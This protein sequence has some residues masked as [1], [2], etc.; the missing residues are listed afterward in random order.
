M[1]QLEEGYRAYLTLCNERKFD[2]LG[3]F[4]QDPLQLNGQTFAL[5][6]FATRLSKLVETV[7]DFRW[8]MIDFVAGNDKLAVRNRTTGTPRAEWLGVIPNGNSVAITEL[9]FYTYRNGKIAEIWF[10]FDLASIRSQLA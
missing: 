3:D 7:P 1:S 6:D 9:V 2:R 8:E 10:L 4:V 5:S